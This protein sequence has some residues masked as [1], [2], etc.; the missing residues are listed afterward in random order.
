[1]K[2]FAKL[3]FFFSISFLVI[4]LTA[5]GV[6]FLGLRVEWAKN[7]PPKPETSLSLL[8]AACRWAL[9][10]A[11]FSSILLSLCYSARKSYSAIMTVI[12]I[13]C[14]SFIF[15]FG[16]S[17]A[18]ENLKSVPPAQTAG[19]PL[20]GKGLILSN[21]LNRNET[22]VVLLN[23][24]AEPLG[25]RV[26]AI[27]DQPLIYHEAAGAN[28]ALP[29]V[30]FGDDTPWFLKS[31]AIDIRL[32]AEM[33]QNKFNEGF[34]PFLIYAGSSIFLLCSLSCAIKFSV[35]PAANLF[36]GV[37]AFRGVLASE[38]FFNTP[39]MQDIISSFL[40]GVIPSSLALPLGFIG[41]GLLL[42]LYSGLMF[43]IKRQDEDDY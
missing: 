37:L 11:L 43:I 29:P 34:L 4:F 9:S 10:L 12:S 18:L 31:L 42:H 25:P 14:L 40:K 32:N 6:R 3:M 2:N 35:W 15:C 24:T 39:G 27:P 36:L 33:F 8:I 13:M 26:I 22:A 23:G 5:A 17:S 7:L 1:M 20:G 19:I 16:I 30:P 38:S 21:S 28:F 41:L